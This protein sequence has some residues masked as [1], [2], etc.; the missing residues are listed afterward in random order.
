VPLEECFPARYKRVAWRSIN[1]LTT[2]DGEGWGKV[3]SLDALTVVPVTLSDR[4]DWNTMVNPPMD[5]VASDNFSGGDGTTDTMQGM[6][7]TPHH[8]RFRVNLSLVSV[9]YDILG[10]KGS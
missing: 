6:P 8:N 7:A 3:N 9:D 1:N 4:L 2:E 10:K 5:C